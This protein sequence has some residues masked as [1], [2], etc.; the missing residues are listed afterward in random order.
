LA[1]ALIEVRQDLIGGAAGIALWADRLAPILEDI[2]G[3]PPD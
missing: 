3:R 2:I 1:D